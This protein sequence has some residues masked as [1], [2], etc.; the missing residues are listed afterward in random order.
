MPLD[1]NGFYTVVISRE[2]DRPR[3]ATRACGIAWLPMADDGDGMYDEDVTIVQIRNMLASP[4]FPHAIQRVENQSD[5]QTT[6]GGY[7]PRG[8]YLQ[9]NQVESFFPCY[10]ELSYTAPPTGPGGRGS[11]VS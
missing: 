7:L 4:D 1:R 2:A 5:L 10:P 9:P 8:L 3:N 6:M 11:A